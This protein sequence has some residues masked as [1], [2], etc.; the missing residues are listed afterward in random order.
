MADTYV[1]LALST[2]AND[3]TS[4]ANA[5]HTTTPIQNG[6]TGAGAGGRCF[7]KTDSA[8]TNID[9]AAASRTLTSPGTSA[10]PTF[11]YG[12]K[13]GTT[14]E[15]PV[16]SDLTTR[17]D[18]DIPQYQAT[19]AGS[20]IEF[21]AYCNVEGMKIEAVDRWNFLADESWQYSRCEVGWGGSFVLNSGSTNVTFNDPELIPSA[22]GAAFFLAGGAAIFINGGILNVG[23]MPTNFIAS[24]R[25]GSLTAVGFDM[26]GFT[27]NVVNFGSANNLAARFINCDLS[28]SATK[29]TGTPTYNTGTFAE[30]VQTNAETGLGSGASIRDYTKETLAGTV[31]HEFTAVRT[32]GADDGADGAYSLALTP[33]V[34]STLESSNAAV[35]SPWIGGIIAGDGTTSKT[36]TIF[37]ANSLAESSPTNDLHADDV[38]MELFSPSATGIARH[39][40]SL[41]SQFE[42]I[43]G[44]T[45]DITSDGSTW[46]S[47]AANAQ[48]LIVTLTPDFTGP[49]YARVHFAKRYAASPVTLYVDPKLDI[50]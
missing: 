8:G 26:S 2:G 18:T 42:K 15:P 7:V 14:N 27:G 19:G 45:T 21:R 47:G 13:N 35:V 43:G 29:V 49:V 11:I 46:G 6:L 33:N 50:A 39:D 9:T 31:E 4:W 24:G 3:G 28:G 25:T 23:T 10:N 36:F 16:D 38:W 1:D 32:S 30:F 40:Y 37:I 5:Y 17:G 41:S 22:T 48:K 34:D 44:G 20:D 12:C